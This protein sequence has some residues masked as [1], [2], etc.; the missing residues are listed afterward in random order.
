MEQSLG[1]FGD[2]HLAKG[3]HFCTSGMP[4]KAARGSAS[5]GWGRLRRGNADFAVFAQSHGDAG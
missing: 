4:R 3:E 1:A 2:E 5:G